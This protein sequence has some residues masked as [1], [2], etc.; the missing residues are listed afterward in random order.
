MQVST[1]GCPDWVLPN[2][3]GAGYYRWTL[4]AEEL[5]RLNA[6]AK[7]SLSTRELLSVGDSLWADFTKG[8]VSAATALELAPW[9]AQHPEREV[10]TVPMELVRFTR[11]RLVR[12]GQ[13]RSVERF[14][15]ELYDDALKRL[16]VTPKAGEPNQSRL[17][18]RDLLAF[19]ARVGRH[20]EVR[21]ALARSGCA[22]IGY[23]TDG[24]IHPE[25]VDADLVPL[26]LGVAV[27]E[28]DAEFLD[29]MVKHLKDSET[30]SVVRRH[31]RAGLVQATEPELA[32][33]VRNLILSGSGR[34]HQKVRLLRRHLRL[35]ENHASGLQWLRENL[36][37]L[38]TKIPSDHGGSLVWVTA[39]FCSSDEAVL[40]QQLFGPSINTRPGGPRDLAAT[41]ETI[42]QCAALRRAQQA[43]ARAFFNQRPTAQFK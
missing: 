13:R 26:A 30:D 28:G 22:Y 40:V 20:P 25:A 18:R 3:D 12:K 9:V 19:L 1:S 2:A 21:R 43:S 29:A 11:N 5:R 10:A 42:N 7:D 8:T 37:K 39:S 32:E 14:A 4:P 33:R 24:L 6:T 23:K 34:T 27:Q 36:E 41:L 16:G 35:S 31:L 15:N 38:L 17:F